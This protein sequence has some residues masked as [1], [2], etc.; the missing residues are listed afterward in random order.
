[1]TEI[2]LAA[3]EDAERLAALHRL[4]FDEPWDA[5]SIASVL[6]MSGAL[7]WM[8][9][10]GGVAGFVLLRVAADEA[11]I[12]TIAVDPAR[13]RHGLGRM[14]V[15]AA[16]TSA[17]AL[18]ARTLFLEVAEDNGPAQALYERAGFLT[19][20]V[21][22]GYYRRGDAAVAARTMRLDLAEAG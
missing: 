14:L 2:V 7:G 21:R 4:S 3:P 8:A 5:A 16:S 10:D 18:G 20:G 22:P 11:E 6:H 12:L 13:R 15:D 19:V 1:M 9:L 17:R